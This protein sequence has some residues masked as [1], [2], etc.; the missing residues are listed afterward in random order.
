MA[1]EAVG[2][3]TWDQ[4]DSAT[5]AVLNYKIDGAPQEE[6]R[7]AASALS[8]AVDHLPV[9]S[10]VSWGLKPF[11]G[12]EYGDEVSGS[13]TVEEPVGP[14]RPDPFQNVQTMIGGFHDS[15]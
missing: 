6:V 1:R 4:N 13:F 12:Q 2:T 9:G 5:V 7:G 14:V 11:N 8:L 3:W 10:V 15:P